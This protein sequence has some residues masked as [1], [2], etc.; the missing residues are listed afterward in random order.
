MGINEAYDFYLPL[1]GGRKN[2]LECVYDVLTKNLEFERLE[3]IETGASHDPIDGSFG[4]FF[5]K[6]AI[7]TGGTFSSVDID[8]IVTEKSK[9]MYQ[10]IFA[11]TCCENISHYCE[12]SVSFL[13]KHKGSPNLIHLDSWDLDIKNPVPS[14]LHGWLEFE[15]IKD[16]M[17]SGSI[18]LI[19]DNFMRN[20][21][22]YWNWLDPEGKLLSTEE[23][24]V[25]Y[26]ILGKGALVYHW[27]L[28]PETDWDLIG[29]HYQTA[30]ENIKVIIKKR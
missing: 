6:L 16:K 20:S 24:E 29:D 15:A 14:M 23:I 12:D 3:V 25:E 11:E 22:I 18:C 26:D 10:S 27:A 1:S 17:P 2:Q 4:I 21:L 28:K 19:D 30:G 8:P 7:L 9:K 5:A 13:K